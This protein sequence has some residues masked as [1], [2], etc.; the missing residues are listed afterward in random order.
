M[1]LSYSFTL[2]PQPAPAIS[3]APVKPT[4][5]GPNLQSTPCSIDV[6]E[7]QVQLLLNMTLPRV[8]L[9]GNLLSD[10]ECAALIEA[11]KAKGMTRSNVV[12]NEVGEEHHRDRTSEGMYFQRGENPLVQRIEARIAR[13]LRW[14][15]DNGEGLQVLHYLPAAQYKPH[16]DYFLP[17]LPSTAEHIAHGGQRVG[18][19]ILY[20]NEVEAGGATVFPDVGLSIMPKRGHA[21][22][23]AYERPDPATR[24]LHGG[25]PVVKG[26]KWIA[27][28]WLREKAYL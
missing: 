7:R 27:T 9:F 10:E 3:V 25:A 14:P 19:L 17:S 8:L 13:L 23:F 4:Q 21:L 12:S 16:Y 6:G 20:L 5:P 22:F 1:Q 11:A 28:K 2:K 15:L 26:E 18:T 24:T